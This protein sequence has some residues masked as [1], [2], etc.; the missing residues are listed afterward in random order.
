MTCSSS[1]ISILAIARAGA[2]AEAGI[3]IDSATAWA[4]ARKRICPRKPGPPIA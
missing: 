1:A 2:G 3:A 4:P